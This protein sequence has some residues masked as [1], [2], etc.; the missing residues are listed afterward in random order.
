[1][2]DPLPRGL[3]SES[4]AAKWLGICSTTLRTLSIPRRALGRRRLYDVRDLEAARDN[5]PYE[6]EG[7]DRAEASCDAAFG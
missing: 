4:D 1:M 7:T 5:L 2:R 6:N 3:L